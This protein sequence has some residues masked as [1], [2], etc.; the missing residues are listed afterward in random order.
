MTAATPRPAGSRLEIEL[1]ADR[2]GARLDQVLAALLPG[3]SR[4]ALQ[5]LL[6]RGLVH[7][8][9]GPA[10]SSYRVRG[11][12]RVRIDLPPP[13]PSAL[14]PEALPLE[15]LH[16]DADLIVIS[17]AAGLTVHPGSGIRRG[18]LVNALLHRCADLSGIG[19]VERPGIVHRLDR[20][21]SGVMVVA[22]HD[23]AHRSLAAQFKART[24]GKV[25][26]ALVWGRP[27]TPAG[28]IDAPIGR[29]PTARVR[30]AIRPAGRPARTA[31]RVVEDLGPLTR[32]NLR[33]E[34]GRTHQLR[35]HLSSI[36]HPIV[37]DPLYGGAALRRRI[38]AVVRALLQ[39]YQGLALHACEL[40]FDHPRTGR[41]LVLQAGRPAELELLL[42]ELRQALLGL[43]ADRPER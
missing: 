23:V 2:R 25:Y 4:A 20:D 11:G 35:V 5:R 1:P 30:M 28:H 37:G 19:G 42:R 32:L 39:T 31:W 29:H 15:V 38:P 12:E 22:K 43:E 16:E 3:H 7:L 40:A 24:V 6:H 34:T 14:Q 41:R 26:E 21:T 27:R 10:R 18:T 8:D 17:K 9:G 13:E 33:P 36:G